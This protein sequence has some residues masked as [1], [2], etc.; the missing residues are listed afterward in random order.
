MDNNQFNQFDPGSGRNSGG[1]GN[2]NENNGNGQSPKKQ[3]LLVL[4]IAALISLLFISYLMRAVTGATI[5][6]WNSIC[7]RRSIF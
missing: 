3:N 4:L 1:Q 6:S 5:R 2:K 7:F